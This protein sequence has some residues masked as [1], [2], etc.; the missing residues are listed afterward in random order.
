MKKQLI[1][2]GLGMLSAIFLCMPISAAEV[3]QAVDMENYAGH[4]GM[5]VSQADNGIHVKLDA[6]EG[7]TWNTRWGYNLDQVLDGLTITLENVTMD[8]SN[9]SG[10]CISIGNYEGAYD[11]DRSLMFI[12]TSTKEDSSWIYARTGEPDNGFIDM[13][14]SGV[15]GLSQGMDLTFQWKRKDADTWI[16]KLNEKEMEFSNEVVSEFI[17]DE[18]FVFVTFG[19]WQYSP[20]VEYTIT[21]IGAQDTTETPPPT[22]DTEPDTSQTTGSTPETSAATTDISGQTTVA[23]DSSTGS[24]PADAD[25]GEGL[26]SGAIALIVVGAVI[27]LSLAA[28]LIY[29]FVLKPQ[30]PKQP[31]AQ[32]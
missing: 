11:C 16:W 9:E 1:T 26:T 6:K 23:N 18:E 15:K 32:Q 30:N 20:T 10:L 2:M 17:D 22:Q 24:A 31:P 13:D 21:S 3:P 7:G 28:F 8:I 27:V 14:D 5:M 25:S 19:G 29:Q 12:L 4:S